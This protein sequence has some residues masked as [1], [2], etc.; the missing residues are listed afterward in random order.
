MNESVNIV[1]RKINAD[2]ITAD[3]V[4]AISKVVNDFYGTVFHEYK[5]NKIV[6]DTYGT[7]LYY[8]LAYRDNELFGICPYHVCVKNY[9]TESFSNPTMYEIP[10]GGWVWDNRITDFYALYKSI[11]TSLNEG[12]TTTTSIH[13]KIDTSDYG[14]VRTLFTGLTDLK[15]KE[16]EI[17]K[18]T[19]DSKRRN[20]IR[21]AEKSGLK[22]S[23]HGTEGLKR[24]YTLLEDMYSKSSVKV[25]PFEF[26]ES[27]LNNL[28]CEN[29]AVIVLA[30]L[31]DKYLSGALITGN[32]NYMHYW[33][34]ASKKGVDNLGQG[35]LV[36][37]EAI[38]WSKSQGA[39][40]YDLC[41]IEEDRL[42]EIA[43]FKKGFTKD[44]V[45]FYLFGQRKIGFKIL[46]RIINRKI[47]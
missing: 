13:T 3:E 10:Y 18:T 11:K 16:E 6:S 39:E 36:Q 8:F 28:Y 46:Y 26:Y 32:K 19:I 7:E 35:E 38:K 33:Q 21:K 1:V 12:F 31:N 27:V 25:K 45:P 9:Y 24:F 29:K 4:L 40:Y 43:R 41:V 5:I 17:W 2:K 37:W 44:I 23:F 15:R 47:F 22:I 20:M 34:G 42:P 14:K 30:S